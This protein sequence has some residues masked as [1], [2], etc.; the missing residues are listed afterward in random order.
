MAESQTSGYLQTSCE[1][2]TNPMLSLLWIQL[3]EAY[4]I[5]K[6]ENNKSM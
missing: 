4:A 5:P 1:V 6:S 3:L 2:K